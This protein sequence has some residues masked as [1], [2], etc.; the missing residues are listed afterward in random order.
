MVCIILDVEGLEAIILKY[1]HVKGKLERVER[2]ERLERW[3]IALFY[4][5]DGNKPFVPSPEPDEDKLV[6]TCV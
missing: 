1:E 6:S 4:D 3:V 2:V 5:V